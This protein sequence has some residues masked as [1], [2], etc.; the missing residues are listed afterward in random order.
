MFWKYLAKS[1]LEYINGK[2][3]AVWWDAL[4]LYW[5]PEADKMIQLR[6]RD[7]TNSNMLYLLYSK[8]QRF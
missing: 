1:C 5:T 3:F 8:V 7:G 6:G 2:L 4:R